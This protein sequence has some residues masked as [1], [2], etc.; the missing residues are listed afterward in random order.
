MSNVMPAFFLAKV[1]NPKAGLVLT[2]LEPLF[3]GDGAPE[4]E[5]EP[6]ER[7]ISWAVRDREEKMDEFEFVLENNDMTLW[8]SE[9]LKIGNTVQFSYGRGDQMA[10]PFVGKITYRSGWRTIKIAG[11]FENEI[12]ITQ[13]QV[14]EKFLKKKYSQIAQELFVRE[15]LKAVVDATD[16]TYDVTIRRD[17]TVFQFLKRLAG[18]IPG[19]YQ[20]YV[21]GD[22]GYFVK[23]KVDAAPNYI[24]KYGTEDTDEEYQTIGEPEFTNDQRN[25]ATQETVRGFDMLNKKAIEEKGNNDGSKL[26]SLGKGTYYFDEAAGTRKLR[27]AQ[28]QRP[29]ETGLTKQ[30]PKQT[31]GEALDLAQAGF[32]KKANKQFQL[33]WTVEGNPRF[34]A[35]KV[36]MVECPSKAISGRW[37]IEEVE[38]TGD[39]GS[40]NTT[41][42]MVRNALGQATTT[43]PSPLGGK[44]EKAADT[45]AK[46]V[47]VFDEKKGTR[48]PVKKGPG[49]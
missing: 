5:K 34:K 39:G 32:D 3:Y 17:E 29:A 30:T 45:K 13:T 42:K 20:V 21:D 44:N 28:A 24:L 36:V 10:G 38:H 26:T 11:E 7:L 25:T 14:T 33:S 43:S 22:T 40:M 48:V 31:K 1:S 49:G 37:Y 16:K 35:K 6:K 4:T 41:L 23:R 18:E 15:G 9:W 47:Y 2:D 27:P 8:D 19:D 12:K 46:V